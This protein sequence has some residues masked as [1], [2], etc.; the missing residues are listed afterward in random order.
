MNLNYKCLIL[1]LFTFIVVFPLSTKIVG[2]AYFCENSVD[3]QPCFSQCYLDLLGFVVN[4]CD[5][6]CC[7]GNICYSDYR[8][9]IG[10]ISGGPEQGFK[11]GC[12][13]EYED[14]NP[15]SCSD[16]CGLNSGTSV[17]TDSGWGC[18]GTGVCSGDTPVCYSGNCVCQFDFNCDDGNPCTDDA[19]H[20]DWFGC[21]EN[22]CFNEPVTCTGCTS[23]D[24]SGSPGNCDI[25]GCSG[26]TPVCYFG[27]CVCG[28]DFDCDD[29]N[30]CTDDA[31][32]PDW[33]GCDEN[34]CFNEPVTC[35]WCTSC[36]PSG[37]PGNCDIGG[38]GECQKCEDSVCKPEKGE[39]EDPC[40]TNGYCWDGECCPDTCPGGLIYCVGYAAGGSTGSCSVTC[41]SSG[42]CGRTPADEGV[43]YCGV[44]PEDVHYSHIGASSEISDCD[45]EEYCTSDG[46][47]GEPPPPLCGNG[48]IDFGEE[49]DPNASPD[50]CGGGESC[51]SN[52]ECVSVG[53][54]SYTKG[55]CGVVC[56]K[57]CGE[58]PPKY[59][60]E[61]G[62]TE[63]CYVATSCDCTGAKVECRTDPS[64]IDCDGVGG[65]N[66]YTKDTI[67]ECS[68]SDAFPVYYGSTRSYLRYGPCESNENLCC[69]NDLYPD[70][71][72]HCCCQDVKYSCDSFKPSDWMGHPG[73]CGGDDYMGYDRNWIRNQGCCGGVDICSMLG[74]GFD[75]CEDPD[76]P[77][78]HGCVNTKYD[79]S[80][81]G[82]CGINCTELHG[83]GQVCENGFCRR[84]RADFTLENMALSDVDCEP[85]YTE[86]DL[87]EQ[88]N[89]WT[90]VGSIDISD[91]DFDISSMKLS[92]HLHNSEFLKVKL[93]SP[94]GTEHIIL[95]AGGSRKNFHFTDLD[96]F[97]GKRAKGIW[98]LYLKTGGSS[99]GRL[100]TWSLT[101]YDVCK[102]SYI[103]LTDVIDCGQNVPITV[104][105]KDLGEV[106]TENNNPVVELLVNGVA[107]ETQTATIQQGTGEE[108][109]NHVLT[110]SCYQ[111]MCD[112]H[113]ANQGYDHAGKIEGCLCRCYNWPQLSFSWIVDYPPT[114]GEKAYGLKLKADP[115]NHYAESNEGN[116]EVTRT[117]KLVWTYA[118]E[119][120]TCS[121]MG[122]GWCIPPE[123][124]DGIDLTGSASDAASHPGQTCCD[125]RC[126]FITTDAPNI[127][128]ETEYLTKSWCIS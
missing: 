78:F 99:T 71:P 69:D 32:H 82:G 44:V 93:V 57:A 27:K 40:G 95:S 58:F 101:F 18:T 76:N 72:N 63:R 83:P 110:H 91:I 11:Y 16:E 65:V 8:E 46:G 125:G 13:Y 128:I 2:A 106:C 117:V 67:G 53:E 12:W 42:H 80:N 7:D 104:G 14:I 120:Q 28:V 118:C 127:T 64:C 85:S 68:F 50:G 124:C 86:G 119:M 122:G 92:I 102:S 17:C 47:C 66:K 36:D 15:S 34:G 25:G 1:I 81:C 31:C 100:S 19:C 38:C 107:E 121:E 22:G 30:P 26:D 97:T 29:G 116:N 108:V 45:G 77:T 37:S 98:E 5:D 87:N 62:D 126:I 60:I 111:S 105:L 56:K 61:C 79:T 23:C 90:H 113:C 89:G 123:S 96:S 9:D 88:F 51:N 48:V 55:D 115:T 35:F 103:E 94:D 3:P 43:C 39:D 4:N 70:I 74:S 21:D 112:S 49:C 75:C 84:A 33:F 10:C 52:C 6:T 41:C 20:P 59:K 109:Y 24:P 73:T 114:P 54:C